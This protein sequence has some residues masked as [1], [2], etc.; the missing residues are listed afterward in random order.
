MLSDEMTT[1]SVTSTDAEKRS[2]ASRSHAWNIQQKRFREAFPEV[3]FL[4]CLFALLCSLFV[5]SGTA[6]RRSNEVIST[7]SKM[8]LSMRTPQGHD[9]SYDRHHDKGHVAALWTTSHW[10]L[11]LNVDRLCSRFVL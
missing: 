10:L 2:Y 6:S 9:T 7:R 8:M 3:S 5:R 1:G 11:V 4:S